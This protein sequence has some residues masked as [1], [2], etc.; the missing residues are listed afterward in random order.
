MHG[1]FK[2]ISLSKGQLFGD[3][4]VIEERPR[5]ATATCVSHVGCVFR[6]DSAE[7]FRRIESS[8]ET[9]TE[10]RKQLYSKQVQTKQRLAMIEAVYNIKPSDILARVAIELISGVVDNKTDEN[11]SAS[12]AAQASSPP[13][14]ANN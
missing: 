6:I 2:L 11:P 9:K 4:D 8:E 10:V 12:T 1:S 13:W 5:I 3:D 7:F 14:M